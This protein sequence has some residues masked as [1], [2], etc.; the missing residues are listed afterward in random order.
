MQSK[1]L[2][3]GSIVLYCVGN[4]VIVIPNCKKKKSP[5]ATP[6]VSISNATI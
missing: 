4:I 6:N 1:W 2:G 3:F 5:N